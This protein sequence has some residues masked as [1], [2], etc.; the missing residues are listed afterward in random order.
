MTAPAK[1]KELGA[2]EPDKPQELGAAEGPA[3]APA[4]VDAPPQEVG[5]V[6]ADPATSTAGRVPEHFALW[7]W[8]CAVLSA[9]V[10]G[11][12]YWRM[13]GEQ[14][15]ILKELVVSVVPLGVLTVVVLAVILLGIPP[16]PNR[17]RWVPWARSIWQPSRNRHDGSSGRA[18]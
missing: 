12:Y 9:I 14:L 15:Q 2:A 3:E 6:V 4:A 16:P 17:Q 10:L 18:W 13:D 5:S 7:F 11:I 1:P 8:A